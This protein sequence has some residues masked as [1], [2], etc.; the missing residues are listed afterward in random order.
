MPILID[1]WN[2]IRNNR[3]DIDDADGDALDSARALIGRLERFQENH[4]DPIIVV[5][6]SRLEHLDTGHVNDA[7]LKV[8]ATGNADAYIKKYVD[9]IAEPQRRALRVVSSDS[10]VYYYAKS[11]YATPL[12]SEEFWEKIKRGQTPFRK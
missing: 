10:E 9:K 11:A 12:R 3:S 8:V 4:N 7:R 2:F 5:F 1:G 6:D